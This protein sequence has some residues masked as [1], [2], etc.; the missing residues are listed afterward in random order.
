MN[1]C[2]VV[3]P[4]RQVYLNKQIGEFNGRDEKYELDSIHVCVY[5]P[6]IIRTRVQVTRVNQALILLLKY[7]RSL[8]FRVGP[9]SKGRH[10]PESLCTLYELFTRPLRIFGCD[11]DLTTTKL[12]H[13]VRVD[14]P[15]ELKEPG[16]GPE[17]MRT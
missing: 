7:G 16:F 3:L 11:D 10:V 13:L 4:Q 14:D 5:F 2:V 12:L 9:A 1:P 8:G 17:R 6:S 15:I